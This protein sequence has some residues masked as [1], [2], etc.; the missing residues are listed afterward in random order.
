MAHPKYN[1]DQI[2]IL[3]AAFEAAS[4]PLCVI[5]QAFSVIRAN[6]AFLRLMDVVPQKS[7]NLDLS[8]LLDQQPFKE[9]QKNIKPLFRHRLKPAVPVSFE[10]EGR[11]YRADLKPIRVIDKLAVLITVSD[12][13]AEFA[14]QKERRELTAELNEIKERYSALYERSFEMI[15]LHDFKGRFLDAN[16]A[17]LNLL[18]FSREEIAKIRF[19]TLLAPGQLTT[20]L[21]LLA[22]LRITGKPKPPAIYQLRTK[23]GKLIWVETLASILRKNGRPY[24]VQGIARDV[25]LQHHLREQLSQEIRF[26]SAM[27]EMALKFAGESAPE[28]AYSII[29]ETLSQLFGAIMTTVNIFNPDKYTFQPNIIFSKK[30][31]FHLAQKTLNFKK[32]PPFQI[33]DPVIQEMLKKRVKRINGGLHELSFEQIPKQQARFLE[34]TLGIKTIYA[35]VLIFNENIIGSVTLMLPEIREI[36]EPILLAMANLMAVELSRCQTEQRLQD[37]LADKTILLREI[38]H[39]VKNNLQIISSLLNLQAAGLADKALR[40]VFESCQNRIFSMTL[41]HQLL[42]QSDTYSGIPIKPYI[43]TLARH[44]K[45]TAPNPDIQIQTEIIPDLFLS[46]DQAVPLGLILNE[47]LTNALK[48]AFPGQK[49][50]VIHIKLIQRKGELHLT[51]N[52][53][54]IGLDQ[55]HREAA[56][57]R[58][59]IGLTLINELTMQIHGKIKMTSRRGLRYYI[60]IP[61]EMSAR[62]KNE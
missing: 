11:S 7:G 4:Q 10:R 19:S 49:T 39:R 8:T 58:G 24:A 5:N 32:P 34:K 62:E 33:P 21:K 25:T 42:F 56:R 9:I 52:D 12:Q 30:S 29:G 14:A 20:A 47:I 40:N 43:E 44:L 45:I 18:E 2:Q 22:E 54:G 28:K 50:G 61:L 60:Q 48:H 17:A 37:S 35:L 26:L 59:S 13:S 23:S 1:S 46:I 41:I 16:Q 3:T 55:R 36:P 6:D 53:N 57:S 31:A 51:V 15:Y 38:H 27:N